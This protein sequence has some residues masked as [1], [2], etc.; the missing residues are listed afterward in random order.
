MNTTKHPNAAKLRLDPFKITLFT[1]VFT[2]AALSSPLYAEKFDWGSASRD[3]L[4]RIEF[5]RDKYDFYKVTFKPHS[6]DSMKLNELFEL[7][8]SKLGANGDSKY[9]I[10][11]PLEPDSLIV[12][13]RRS[14]QTKSIKVPPVNPDMLFGRMQKTTTPTINILDKSADGILRVVTSY[15]FDSFD[16]KKYVYVGEDKAVGNVYLLEFSDVGKKKIK[17][18]SKLHKDELYSFAMDEQVDQ[19]MAF[20]GD[21]DV[22]LGIKYISS[23]KTA[24]DKMLKFFSDRLNGM[25][26]FPPFVYKRIE[27]SF[28][29]Q[30]IK[31]AFQDKK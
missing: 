16:F 30:L 25:R 22:F 14:D 15:V 24:P 31:K 7:A 10:M 2:F 8:E 29:E 11:E 9:I 17:A 19:L 12:K 27:A 26:G 3:A 23:S 21:D 13:V 1:L 6:D 4:S 28:V 20:N 5:E 18:I